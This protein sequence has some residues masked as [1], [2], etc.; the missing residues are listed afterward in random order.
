MTVFVAVICA[1]LGLAVGSFLNVVIARLPEKQSVVRPPSRCPVCEAPIASRDNIPVVSYLILRG[2]C[3]ACG[4]EISW[5]YPAVEVATAALFVAMAI[6][7]AGSWVI[8]GFLLF[9]ATL[10]AIAVIDLEHSIIPNR[11]VFP[12]ALTS[13]PLLALAAG[14]DGHW[15]P[16]TR[17]LLG[18]VVDFGVLFGLNLAWPRG[19]GM[20]DV[21]LSFVLGLYL[22]WLG[23]GHIVLSVLLASVASLVVGIALLIRRG[24][25]AAYPFGPFLALGAMLAVF[26]GRPLI[27]LYLGK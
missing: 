6:R 3:R 4:A 11:I 20:G 15:H 2:K 13:I 24:R 14:L 25:S 10:L 26:W 19:M 21:K 18:G 17:A 23:W 16:F 1:V 7:F 27:D 5:R 12:V 9:A 22:G 8:P